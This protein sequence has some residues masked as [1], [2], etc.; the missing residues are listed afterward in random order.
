MLNG[1]NMLFFLLNMFESVISLTKHA[2][3]NV[4]KQMFTKS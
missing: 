4:K 2:I 1:G 3:P